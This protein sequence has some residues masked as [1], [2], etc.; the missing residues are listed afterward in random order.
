MIVLLGALLGAGMLLL[1]SPWLWPT[2]AAGAQ[3][4]GGIPRLDRLLEDAGVAGTLSARM[5]VAI[6]GLGALIAAAVTWLLFPTLPLWLLV[7]LGAVLAPLSWLQGRVRRRRQIHRTL[8]PDVCELLI[9]AVR[10]GM[11]LPDAV[12]SLDTTAPEALRPA[13]WAFARDMSASA[14]FDA[15]MARLKTL[16]ADPVADRIVETLRMAREVGGTEL[17]PTLRALSVSVRADATLRAEVE[18]KQS[19]VRA[20]AWLGAAAPWVILVMLALRPEGA[21]AYASP[22]GVVLILCGAAVTVVAFRLML[23][24]GR[25]AEPRRWFA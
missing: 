5:L 23:R 21:Q 25:L 17:V 9:S 19:W 6:T 24:I 4:R 22:G 10:S 7:A 11:S 3:T 16:L 1:I 12:A 2:P 15:S 14:N 20:A 13:F 18:A 8:W